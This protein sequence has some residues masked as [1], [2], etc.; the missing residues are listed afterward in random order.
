MKKDGLWCICM[1]NQAINQITVKCKYLTP[2]LK[3]M[4][5]QLVGSRLFSKIYL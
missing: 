3:D 4:L 5:D 1:D 2:W